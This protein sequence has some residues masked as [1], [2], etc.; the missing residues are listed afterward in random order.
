[1]AARCVCA[2][3]GTTEE[4]RPS[5]TSVFSRSQRR[6]AEKGKP[7]RCKR[8]IA[9]E[10][11]LGNSS[12]SKVGNDSE[13]APTMLSS[14]HDCSSVITLRQPF[15]SLAASGIL[16]V[17]NFHRWPNG[18]VAHDIPDTENATRPFRL[19]IHASDQPPRDLPRWKSTYSRLYPEDISSLWPAHFPT[20]VLVGCVTVTIVID[21]DT[22][23]FRNPRSMNK[24]AFS[25]VLVVCASGARR[26][27]MPLRLES[28]FSPKKCKIW[29]L[30]KSVRASAEQQLSDPR[31]IPNWHMKSVEFEEK[32]RVAPEELPIIEQ[33]ARPSRRCESQFWQI[34]P[35]AMTD[36]L[37]ITTRDGKL[38]SC[39]PR[40]FGDLTSPASLSSKPIVVWF[41]QDFRMIDN[42]ALY[43][44]SKAA[45]ATRSPLICCYVHAPDS[46]EGISA[47]GGQ[48]WSLGGAASVWTHAALVDLDASLKSRGSAGLTILDARQHTSKSTK[49]C[50][51]EFLTACRAKALYFNR[52]CEPWKCERDK[53]IVEALTEEMKINVHTFKTVV[54]FEPWDAR[55][56]TRSECMAVGFGSVGFFRRAC[57]SLEPPGEP[58]PAPEALHV[59]RI[60]H[61]MMGTTTLDALRLAVMPKSYG[62][63]RKKPKFGRPAHCCKFCWVL[64][65]VTAGSNCPHYGTY[66]KM[67]IKWDAKI[68]EF[69]DMTESG[70]LQSLDL[71]LDEAVKHFDSP[72]RHRA[73]G[74]NTS[75]ISP[76]IRFGQLSP[77]MVVFRAKER[78]GPG[79]SQTFLRRL[80]WRDLAYWSLWRFPDLPDMSFRP[81]YEMQKWSR[82]DG[83]HKLRA[84]K[85]G[86]TGYP[87]VD[88]AMR[89]LW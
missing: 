77:R 28:T 10:E 49:G 69:W 7:A 73:D 76:Y 29:K 55:P 15:A 65:G 66:G 48:N 4:S 3:C 57:S 44:A 42:P 5:A 18:V 74:K 30:P 59:L 19:W 20:N 1:M 31:H 84:W 33:P 14:G 51:S 22:I 52:V 25:S 58:L 89:Q 11:N 56:D 32:A 36:P 6:R 41:R 13:N 38:R 2:A 34:D 26:L 82:D 50:L 67:D 53:S 47:N 12:D 43:Q 8:C 61:P 60:P 79:V 64:K 85:Y 87:L 27:L 9:A 81:H 62:K 39:L 75:V 68:R 88:A 21:G 78:W 86:M 40:S 83:G 72:E 63:R 45:L 80:V 37:R 23:G 54:L 24:E 16:R 70:A 71:F 17:L 46:E 35:Q